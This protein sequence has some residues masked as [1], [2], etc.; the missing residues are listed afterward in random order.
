MN[1]T[2]KEVLCKD[3]VALV[4]QHVTMM[5]FYC[6]FFN[7]AASVTVLGKKIKNYFL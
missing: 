2:Q 3:W 4:K 5:W 1:D 6:L 7:V